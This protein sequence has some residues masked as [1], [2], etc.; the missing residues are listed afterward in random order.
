[1]KNFCHR[2]DCEALMKRRLVNIAAAAS[3][4][5]C[6]ACLC[7]WVRSGFVRD[8][9]SREHGGK[10]TSM[11]YS[12]GGYAGVWTRQGNAAAPSGSPGPWTWRTESNGKPRWQWRWPQYSAYSFR[13]TEANARAS[14][15][16]FQF[17]EL[18]I[19]YWL[20]TLSAWLLPAFC[21]WR[22]WK[23]SRRCGAGLCSKCGYDLRA[24]SERCPEC[25][26]PIP[27]TSTV[28]YTDAEDKKQV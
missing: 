2:L 28:V 4:L 27:K 12:A 23:V 21:G 16:S 20:L 11:F 1:M 17:R 13:P 8:Y 7:L 22:Q 14:G 24:S 18:Q 10:R 3:L 26:T 5:L 15:M 9:V 6:F 25:G 19:P